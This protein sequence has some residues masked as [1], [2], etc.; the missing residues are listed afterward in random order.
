MS[1]IGG[2]GWELGPIVVGHA[3]LCESYRRALT[4]AEASALVAIEGM[5]TLVTLAGQSAVV[6]ADGKSTAVMPIDA[7]CAVLARFMEWGDARL[8]SVAEVSPW[9]IE[10]DAWVESEGALQ[11]KGELVAFDAV[12]N[13][14]AQSASDDESDWGADKRGQTHLSLTLEPGEYVV[15]SAALTVPTGDRLEFVRFR[16]RGHQ[17]V[18]PADVLPVPQVKVHELTAEVVNRAKS[19]KFH[20]HG[21]GGP[22]IILSGSVIEQWRGIEEP[23]DDDEGSHYDLACDSEETFTFADIDGFCLQEVGATAI[24]PLA[25]GV[26]LPRWI[27]ADSAAAVLGVALASDYRQL[28][29]KEEPVWFQSQG[30]KY[31]MM[32]ATDNGEPIAEGDTYTFTLPAG[33]YAVEVMNVDDSVEWNG[34]VRHL[35]GTEEG[36]MVQAYRL[37]RVGD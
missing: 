3:P 22:V 29:R 18:R 35:D 15:E 7:R 27:G 28:V 9:W 6:L 1:S 31:A 24:V 26:L 13:V 25:D 23:D 17:P 37:R 20:G 30:G 4:C 36:A 8:S 34:T 11:V 12:A 16:K 2:F 21:D 19:L 33:R 10:D 5:A 14:R 32:H